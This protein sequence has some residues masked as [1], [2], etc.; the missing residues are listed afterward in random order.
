LTKGLVKG[1]LV[2]VEVT[3][4]YEA[5]T[6]LSRLLRRVRAGEEIIIAEAGRPVARLVPIAPPAG[7]RSLGGDEELVWVA[8]DFDAPLPDELVDAFYGNAGREGLEVVRPAGRPAAANAAKK[9]VAS[10]GKRAVAPG[11][12]K[13]ETAKARTAPRRSV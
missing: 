10:R 12:K 8:D 3:N 11:R 1:I 2:L 7:P 13:K 5:K 4:V 9:A 6:H